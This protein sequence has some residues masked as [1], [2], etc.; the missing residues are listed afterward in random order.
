MSVEPDIDYIARWSGVAPPNEAAR[1]AIADFA[2]LL[3]ELERLRG[4]LIFEMEPS[5]FEQAMRDCR[6]PSR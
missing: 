3:A 2:A 5:G 1:M 4:G 6:E